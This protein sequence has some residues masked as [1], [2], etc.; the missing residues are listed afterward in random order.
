MSKENKM[1][2]YS[3]QLSIKDRLLM[4]TALCGEFPYNGTERIGV[5][6]SYAKILRHRLY[7]EEQIQIVTG[8][9]FKGIALTNKTK[10]NIR[11]QSPTRYQYV[12]SKSR[13]EESRRYRK[14]LFALTYCSLVNADIE[15][16]PD[17]K[18]F[19]FTRSRKSQSYNAPRPLI[20][21][22]L[23]TDEPVFYSSVEI[24]YELE[25]YVQQIRNSAMMGLILTRTDCYVVYNIHENRYPLSYATE[26]KAGIL[27]K[28]GEII[29]IK[30]EKAAQAIMLT[31]DYENAVAM[32]IGDKKK[33]IKPSPIILNEAFNHLFIVPETPEG[34]VQLYVLCHSEYRDLIDETFE[35]HYG[36]PNVE[37]ITIN[38]GFD[39][40]GNPVINGC[41]L[42]IIRL[43][44]FKQGLLVNDITGRILCYDFQMDFIK[45][46]MQPANIIFNHIK[47]NDIKEAIDG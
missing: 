17:Q 38:D 9:E 16:L 31:A 5:T 45:R 32:I 15:F 25:D 11:T 39:K 41:H 19:V 14:Q 42:D 29:H 22:S 21:N 2:S 26:L 27:T 4:I 36:K 24:K 40:E 28:N 43:I 33:K 10:R 7:Q 6:T 34:D 23:L 1:Q 12:D 18:P 20:N 8:A 13:P 37:F 46:I 35:K 47:I 3:Q 30:P 44:K